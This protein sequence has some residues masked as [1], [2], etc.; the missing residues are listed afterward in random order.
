MLR[1]PGVFDG[2]AELLF[3]VSR[4]GRE[5]EVR[6]QMPRSLRPL[7]KDCRFV[8]CEGDVLR[9]PPEQQERIAEKYYGGEMPWRESVRLGEA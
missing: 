5:M 4:S 9:L 2:Q 3:A 1:I 7:C 8:F 6:A